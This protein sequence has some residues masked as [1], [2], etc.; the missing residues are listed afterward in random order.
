MND[1]QRKYVQNLFTAA[2]DRAASETELEIWLQRLAKTSPFEVLEAIM[3]SKEFQNKRRVPVAFQAGHYY[4]PIVDPSTVKNYVLEE[5]RSLRNGIPG[6]P[7]DGDTMLTFWDRNLSF[8]ASTPDNPTKSDRRY[9]HGDTGYPLG[10]AVFLRGVINELKPKRIIEIGSG[11]STACMLDAIE[12]LNLDCSITCVEPYPD[13]LLGLLR[14]PDEVTLLQKPVQDV[15]L[16]LF[17]ELEAG[18]ILF[19][20]S[21][22]VIKTGSDVHF[23]LFSILPVLAPGVWIHFHDVPYPFEYP[24]SWIHDKNYSWNEAYGVRAFLMYNNDF[25][26][27]VW[28]TLFATVYRNHI[29]NT[30]PHFPKNPGSGVWLKRLS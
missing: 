12:E 10:D 14:S 11:F 16:S 4:S 17:A 22:H 18:D 21:T 7:I 26:V 23:E 20:D 1:E 27:S 28:N 15:E 9:Y 30:F 13:R 3:R 8:M 25:Q 6:V 2:L 5:R 19:V 29:R 24:D